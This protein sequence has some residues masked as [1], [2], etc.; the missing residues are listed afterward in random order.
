L[1]RPPKD[2]KI[3]PIDL[4]ERALYS[5]KYT[6]YTDEEL[7]EI[8]DTELLLPDEEKASNYGLLYAGRESL[9]HNGKLLHFK[10]IDRDLGLPPG[11]GKR[12]M[13]RVAERYGLKPEYQSEN[14]IRFT[15]VRR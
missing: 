10:Q 2:V 1:S 9:I 3:E 7:I 5:G 14:T 4:D 6:E 11:T 8:I 13:T 12:L 15:R